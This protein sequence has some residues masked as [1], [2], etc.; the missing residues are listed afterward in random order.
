MINPITAVRRRAIRALRQ[1]ARAAQ[2]RHDWQVALRYW[3]AILKL[4]PTNANAGL[5]SANMLNELAEYDRAK[6]FFKQV[7]ASA[8]HRIH[9][10]VGLAGVAVRLGDWG[11]AREHWN[12]TLSLMAAEETKGMS[13]KPWPI[14]PAEALLHLAISCYSLGDLPAA[15]RN[16][17]AAFAIEPKIRRSREAWLI[18]ARL[19]ARHDLRASYRLLTQAHRL[20]PDDYSIS[21]EAIKAAA[22][23]GD[24]SGASRLAET[25]KT[26]FPDDRNARIFLSSLGLAD[27]NVA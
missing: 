6:D 15:E 1:K 26:R 27:V 17:F 14:S 16:L 23:C 24:R 12:A 5:Q 9:G 4:D 3:Q 19:L 20:Y 18:R 8:S 22:G 11:A 10:E 21:Y 7:G 13:R 25:L 2:A